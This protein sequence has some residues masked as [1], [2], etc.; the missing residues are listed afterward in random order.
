MK[1]IIAF[2][3]VALA[4]LGAQAQTSGH[5]DVT[6]N[7][8]IEFKPSPGTGTPNIASFWRIP[9]P[10]LPPT[11]KYQQ[12][13]N[14]FFTPP[15]QTPPGSSYVF[16]PQ[17]ANLFQDLLQISDQANTA[18]ISMGIMNGSGI[19][20]VE[21]DPSYTPI[22]NEALKLNPGCPMDVNICEG[23]GL[24]RI[25]NGADVMGGMSLSSWL[26]MGGGTF[27]NVSAIEA[28]LNSG[29]SQA[30]SIVN[31]SSS[32]TNKRIFEVSSSGK[33][34]IGV[35]LQTLPSM[36]SI[37]Q[38]VKT[39]LAICMTDN[40]TTTNKHF[41]YVYGNGQTY[42]GTDLQNTNS[43]FT[44]G[45]ASKTSLALSLTDNT[46]SVNKAFCNI[47]GSGQTF[48]GPDLQQNTGAMLTVGQA[49]KSALALSLTDN[50][51]ATNKDFF[52]VYGN[53]Y[54]EIKVYS[55][56][57]MPNDR[58]LAIKD[59]SG[60]NP[61]DLFVVKK[62][63]KV[64]AR[65]VEISLTNPFPDY[66]FDKGYD[67]KPISEVSQ[68]IQEHKHLPGFKKGEYYETNG[69]NV[70]SMMVKQQEK[71]RSKCCTLSSCN[72]SCRKS[73]NKLRT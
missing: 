2:I 68:Y 37:G 29:Q 10:S 32:A 60:Q 3:L 64:F 28:N 40:T 20:A 33:T 58:V 30:V 19:L 59:V 4:S 44:V 57:A 51:T 46:S 67:L 41:Y 8:R 56:S 1:K 25:F 39:D 5:I 21:S 26:R 63:G 35:N 66:V 7:F 52:N 18:V 38:S 43:M 49:N 48:I 6:D 71:S 16:A 62:N 45:Q 70:S 36:L 47:Y 53:G 13:C 12:L 34:S 24:T 61:L 15:T 42:I 72:R 31:P 69:I 22:G 65:E 14:V 54:T 55:P 50:T 73:A 27:N 11:P 17:S 9:N 23:G